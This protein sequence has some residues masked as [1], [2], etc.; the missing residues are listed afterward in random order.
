MGS[1]TRQDVGAREW[2]WGCTS[3]LVGRRR[4]AS[5]VCCWLF[6]SPLQLLRQHKFYTIT[7]TRYSWRATLARNEPTLPQGM[8]GCDLEKRTY[9]IVVLSSMLRIRM[10]W[11][12]K[13]EL[14]DNRQTV[15]QLAVISLWFRDLLRCGTSCGPLRLGSCGAR[16]AWQWGMKI[17]L[18]LPNL[19][20]CLARLAMG[21]NSQYCLGSRS[22]II[23]HRC[24]ENH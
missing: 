17:L 14:I 11:N 4:W 20:D 3:S 9:E 21:S 6:L 18:W 10:W 7:A 8:F 22:C 19:K 5:P 12:T 23:L 1:S 13:L 16:R 24:G 2:R 15:W